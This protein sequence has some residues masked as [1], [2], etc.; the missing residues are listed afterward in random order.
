MLHSEAIDIVREGHTLSLVDIGRD[1]GAAYT[2]CFCQIAYLEVGRE[3]E[4]LGLEELVNTF[5]HLSVLH[6][7]R[8]ANR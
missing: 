2:R 5:S 3:I 7:Q 1:V 4:L 6:G 8:T